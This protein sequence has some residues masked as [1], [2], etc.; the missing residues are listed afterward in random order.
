MQ[1]RDSI[2][3]YHTDTFCLQYGKNGVFTPTAYLILDTYVDFPNEKSYSLS[4][5]VDSGTFWTEMIKMNEMSEMNEMDKT[6]EMND[7]G[8]MNEMIEMADTSER[9]M[10]L[11]KLKVILLVLFIYDFNILMPCM[12]LIVRWL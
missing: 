12:Y 6:R 10:F 2:C 9:F 8:G 5:I 1:C 7:M 4:S 11:E 3:L